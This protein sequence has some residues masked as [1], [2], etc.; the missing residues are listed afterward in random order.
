M[1]ITDYL[2]EDLVIAGI[3]SCSKPEALG[4]MVDHLISAGKLSADRREILLSKLM[5][6]ES[7]ASTGIGGGVAIPHASGENVDNMILAVGQSPNGVEFDSIDGHPAKVIFL[8]VGS[9]RAP[10][11]HLQMLAMIVKICKSQDMIKAVAEA[12]APSEIFGIL[13]GTDNR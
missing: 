6:R 9:E 7:L 8:I 10:R 2:S 11:M 12:Q 1:R 5:E 4:A 13:S 3:P